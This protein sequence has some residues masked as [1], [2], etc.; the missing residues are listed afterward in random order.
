MI[1]VF[2]KQGQV[3]S[4]PIEYILSLLAKNKS[5]QMVLTHDKNNAQ[6]IFDHTDTLSLPIN[7]QLYDS[8]INKKIFNHELHL[9]NKTP[10]IFFPN[11]QNPDWL[12]TAFY[13]I[14]SFQEYD[15]SPDNDSLDKYG[16]FRYDKSYQHKFNCIEKNLV[17]EYFDN[18]WKENLENIGLMGES[19]KSKIFISHDIDTIY[20]SLFEDGLWAIKKGR[21]DIVLNLLMNEILLNPH[22]KNIDKIAKINSEY[23]LLSTFFWLTTKKVATNRI[24]NA[25]YSIGKVQNLISDTNFNGLHKSC[26]TTSF[27]EELKSLP[28]KT[29]INRY[30]YLKINVPSSW[31]DLE[32]AGLRFD[33]SLGF[34]ERYG[35]RNS[36]GLPFK[37]YNISTQTSYKIV[38]VPL[39][40]MDGT[41]NRY[42]KIPLKE[43]ASH[44]IDFIENNLTNTIISIV[45]HNTYFT[46]YKY[47]G[48]LEEYKKVLLHLNE[49][50]IKFVTPKEIIDEY[51]KD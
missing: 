25:D 4:K 28:F 36:Y 49:S 51:G 9:I 7:I 8:L 11:S 10:I 33:T 5:G 42:M 1:S 17:Q 35:F 16:R 23:D 34:A 47:S 26:Y 14:N 30:H 40:I 20:G 38:E 45:W 39:N 48:Y 29:D 18:F 44:M 13:M 50:G 12:G 31:A 27:E 24:K 32:A 46:H 43:T 19:R 6:L 3:Y 37:P 21:I 22:W 2:I 15:K 41:I